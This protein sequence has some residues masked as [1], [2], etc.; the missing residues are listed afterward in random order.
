MPELDGARNRFSTN[1]EHAHPI[2]TWFDAGKI[3]LPGGEP[4]MILPQPWSWQELDLT[5]R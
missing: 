5:F 3:G 4:N 1:S 2:L